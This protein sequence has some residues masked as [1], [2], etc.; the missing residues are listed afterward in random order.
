MRRLWRPP[1]LFHHIIEHVTSF[2]K[3]ERDVLLDS[4]YALNPDHVV[5]LHVLHSLSWLTSGCLA[6]VDDCDHEFDI[7]NVRVVMKMSGFQ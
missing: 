6:T 3:L 5:E 2:S 7:Q 1:S 4:C